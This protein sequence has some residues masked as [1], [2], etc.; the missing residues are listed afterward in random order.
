MTPDKPIPIHLTRST[1]DGSWEIEGSSETITIGEGQNQETL[2]ALTVPNT[3]WGHELPETGG[4]GVIPYIVG[5]T[6]LIVLSSSLLLYI[7]ITNA[8]EKA[9]KNPASA[10]KNGGSCRMKNADINIK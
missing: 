2:P 3:P 5:G 7:A 9:K 8:G 1:V 4:K 10:K 6:V